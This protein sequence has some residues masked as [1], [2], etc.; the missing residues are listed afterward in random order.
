M[1]SGHSVVKTITAQEQNS[2]F[3]V[4]FGAQISRYIRA[5]LIADI[6]FQFFIVRHF[7]H[8]G[9]IGVALS[10]RR[11]NSKSICKQCGMYV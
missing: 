7:Y 1:V 5:N 8:A 9:E 10:H 2:T 3:L 11:W 6:R 4:A